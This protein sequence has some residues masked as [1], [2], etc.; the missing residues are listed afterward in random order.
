M[1]LP[2]AAVCATDAA[3]DMSNAVVLLWKC[4]YH[5][6]LQRLKVFHT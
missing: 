4:I 3:E 2:C 1:M 6:K 5:W